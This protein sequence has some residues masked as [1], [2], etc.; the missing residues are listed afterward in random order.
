ML[1]YLFHSLSLLGNSNEPIHP[2]NGWL[3]VYT[4]AQLVPEYNIS[5]DEILTWIGLVQIIGLLSFG[6]YEILFFWQYDTWKSKLAK[7]N[8]E[9]KAQN[10]HKVH[11]INKPREII[12]RYESLNKR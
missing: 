5:R 11:K 3:F 10:G 9:E 1:F 2:L 4:V 8:H 12:T 7:D 6:V